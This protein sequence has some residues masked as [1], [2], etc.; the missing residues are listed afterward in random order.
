MKLNIKKDLVNRDQI[1]KEISE[2]TGLSSKAVLQVVKEFIGLF[3]SGF[4]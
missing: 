3:M 2:R 1:V 4:I